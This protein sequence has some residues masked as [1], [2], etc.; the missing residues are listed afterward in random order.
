MTR[1][2]IYA[3]VSTARQAER[4]LSLPDQIA[5]CRA[6]CDAAGVGG[7]G[8]VL[9]ARRVRA[10]RGSSRLPGDGLQ[11][12]QLRPAVRLHRRSFAQPLQPRRSSF[13]ALRAQAAQGGSGTRLDLPGGVADPSGEMVRKLLNVFDEHQSRENAKHVHRSMCEN[14]RQGFWNGSHPPYGYETRSPSAVAGRIR[15]FSSS[16]KRR[17]KWCARSSPS[18]PAEKGGR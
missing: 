13:R 17:P 18:R 4:D 9:R 3:R 7:P 5:Q 14:A 16:M 2:A 10:R 11:S 15:G 12:H 1:A 6:Y 8:S